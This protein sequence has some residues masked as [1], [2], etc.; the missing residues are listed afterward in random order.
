MDTII[1]GTLKK[2]PLDT[3]KGRLPTYLERKRHH[4]EA[5]RIIL[6]I[7]SDVTSIRDGAFS[8]IGRFNSIVIP[9]SVTR[10]D[11]GV[12]WLPDLDE[13]VVESG[14]EY[15]SSIDGVLYNKIQ[16]ELIR[17]PM[18]KRG[19][20][21]IPSSVTSICEDAFLDCDW[22]EEIV[23][24]TEN[25][26]YSSLD[27]VLYNKERTELIKYPQGKSGD[28]IIPLGVSNIGAFA[29]VSCD[30]LKNVMIPM[31][32]TSIG[33]GAFESCHLLTSV[34]IPNSLTCI[35][36]RAFQCCHLLESVKIP[37]GVKCIGEDTFYRAGLT[38]IILPSTVQRI[39]DGAFQEC[40]SLT[41]IEIPSSVTSIGKC[42]FCSCGLLDSVVI[43]SS[44]TN[45]GEDAFAG[46]DG[47]DEFVV[48]N[49]NE[50]YSS[51]DGILYNKE[52]TELIKCPVGKSG[53][54]IIP[55]S[56]TNIKPYAFAGCGSIKNVTFPKGVVG[57]GEGAFRNC[58]ALENVMIPE[59]VKEM[60]W[61][62]FEG[63][64]R[65]TNLQFPKDAK[66][67][68]GLPMDVDDMPF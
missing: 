6:T 29:F 8:A 62:A 24:E 17:C 37:D 14:N 21:I 16:T 52:Q 47:V 36:N 49:G 55:E 13:I 38:S 40:G 28:V 54:V 33:D 41:H 61:N 27:G 2:V 34:K 35:G 10:V 64:C 20:L 15:Y 46:C 5:E 66:I 45:I 58:I 18:G 63:C 1:I 7:S 30:S 44:V 19:G 56:V 60:G 23:V 12:F 39:G 57:I 53:E 67:I 4:P 42:A 51:L 3:E 31:G 25:K 32:V 68:R 59:S 48:E 50:N 43:P 9:S 11:A 65:L 26:V 22:L